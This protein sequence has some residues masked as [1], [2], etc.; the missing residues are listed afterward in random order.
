MSLPSSTLSSATVIEPVL[1][2]VR[3]DHLFKKRAGKKKCCGHKLADG[4]ECLVPKFDPI[5]IG[6]PMSLNSFGSPGGGIVH[7]YQNYKRLW[8]QKI[9]TELQRSGLP[10]GWA[11][12]AQEGTTRLES[13]IAEG[14]ICFPM[15]RKDRD[16]GNFRWFIEK[17]LGDAL[18]A[19]GWIQDDSFWPEM[20]YSFGGLEFRVEPKLAY[21]QIML[22]PAI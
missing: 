20:H 14:L 22:F 3:A 16:Q 21:T 6:L 19:G 2:E 15:H 13:V 18:E 8:E 5:H 4:S 1:I 10:A 17:C 12:D 9:T 7:T 11:D